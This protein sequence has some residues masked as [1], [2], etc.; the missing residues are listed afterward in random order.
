M[1]KVFLD[2]GHG[3]HDSGALGN[4]RRER[5]IALSVILKTG[6]MLKSHGFQVEYSRID[7]VYLSPADRAVKANRLKADIFVLV[8]CNA[9]INQSAKGVKTFSYPGSI[10]GNILSKSIQAGIIASSA[11]T[12]DRGTKTSNFA[13]L[14]LTN[15]PAALTE[16][17]KLCGI[18]N[19]KEC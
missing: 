12:V 5:D 17:S 3:G 8:H 10:K 19:I 4:G 7:D 18:Y 13:V 11:Y 6:N 2:A 14:R 16:L 1:L 9:F 15:M